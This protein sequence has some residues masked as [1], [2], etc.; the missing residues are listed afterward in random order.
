MKNAL[1]S[2]YS[3]GLIIV[4]KKIKSGWDHKTPTTEREREREEKE[5]VRRR[6]DKEILMRDNYYSQPMT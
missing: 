2:V 1:W 3:N 4:L 6:R 5:R